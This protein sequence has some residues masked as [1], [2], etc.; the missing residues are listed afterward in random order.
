MLLN[1]THGWLLPHLIE[2][3]AKCLGRYEIWKHALLTGEVTPT[4]TIEF[5]NPGTPGFI[6]TQTM[7]NECCR[8][9]SSYGDKVRSL[10]YLSDWILFALGYPVQSELPELPEFSKNVPSRLAKIF[11]LEQLI[12]NP[13]DYFGYLLATAQ[14]GKSNNFYPTLQS[15]ANTMA[16]IA[17]CTATSTGKKAPFRAFEPCLG[18]GRLALA[19]SSDIRCLI[20]WEY[21]RL[22]LNLATTNFMLYAP[23]LA[24]PLPQFG[25][26]LILGNGLSGIGRS[27]WSGKKYNTPLNSP[28]L[29]IQPKPEDVKHRQLSLF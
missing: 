1:P 27:I 6:Q 12:H 11:D 29:V 22:L 26:D 18:T 4:S 15:V 14:Y 28:E 19:L 13:A 10:L 21:D 23:D 7:L 2:L 16:E 20:G 17:V 25:G 8:A 24:M 5:L 3:D 9:I